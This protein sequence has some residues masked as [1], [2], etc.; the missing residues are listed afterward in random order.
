MRRLSVL[1][2]AFF[3]FLYSTHHHPPH[4]LKSRCSQLVQKLLHKPVDTFSSSCP[5]PLRSEKRFMAVKLLV[6]H[7]QL[8]CCRST[9]ISRLRSK[10]WPSGRLPNG[11]SFSPPTSLRAQSLSRALERS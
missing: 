4:L 11:R 10:I 7:C 6:E 8:V 2:A 9:A 1:P 3:R 5:V